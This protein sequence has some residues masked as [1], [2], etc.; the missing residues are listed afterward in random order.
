MYGKL[1]FSL[2]RKCVEDK[3]QEDCM[4][5]NKED[6][7]FSGTWVSEK[8]KKAV[9]VDYRI[10]KFFKF[11]NIKSHNITLVLIKGVYSQDT[12]MNFSNRRLLYPDFL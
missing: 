3:V 6:R 4:H 10:K 7:V 12:L 2:C 9:D 8:V 1:N 5:E 11:G